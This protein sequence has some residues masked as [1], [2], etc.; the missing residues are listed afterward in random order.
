MDNE[1]LSSQKSND[2]KI[3][4]VCPE[5]TLESANRRSLIRK[6]A[7]ATAAV[8]L[9][10]TLLGKSV[11]PESSAKSDSNCG[12][13][14]KCNFV[15]WGDVVI[16]LK[17]Q[18]NGS[19]CA[20]FFNY[21]TCS[22]SGGFN[23]TPSHLLSFGIACESVC[24]TNFGCEIG[25]I[26]SGE[27]IG[28]ARTPGAV[29][30]FGL[31]FY[32]EYT[33]RMSISQHGNVGIGNSTPLHLL[34]I[35]DNQPLFN[36]NE[37]GNVGIGVYCPS[38]T[39][40]VVG[41]GGNIRAGGT[42][43]AGYGVV[44]DRGNHNSGTCIAPGLV[45]GCI[46]GVGSGEGMNSNRNCGPNKYGLD[47]YTDF[48]KRMSISH[49]GNVGIGIA[50]P[51]SSLC[52]VSNGG[53][54]H[55]EGSVVA[56][57]CLKADNNNLN[58]GSGPSQ[59]L[60]FGSAG[61]VGISSA[62]ASG[63]PNQCGLDFYT[64][65]AKRVSITKSG[66]V[67]IGTINPS[68]QLGVLSQSG[69]AIIGCSTDGTGVYGHTSGSPGYG[70]AGFAANT[71]Y[72][73]C[74]FSSKGIGVRGFGCVVGVQGL[75]NSSVA[76]PIV[77]KGTSGQTAPLQEWQNCAGTPLSVLNKC[78]WL[79][80]GNS[81]PSTPL[82]VNSPQWL[83]SRFRNSNASS[84]HSAL[85]QMETSDSTPYQWNIGAAG[86]GNGLALPDG[87]FYFEQMT[88]CH[89]SG[90][91]VVITKCGFVGIGVSAPTIPLDVA[92]C[93]TVSGKLVAG[94][95]SPSCISIP[96]GTISVS[97]CAASSVALSSTSTSPTGI[98]I[99]GTGGSIG[100]QGQANSATAIPLVAKAAGGQ[101][102]PLLQFEKSCGASLSVVNPCG[103]LGIG[104][105]S[106]P[107]TLAVAGSVSAKIVTPSGVYQMQAN[108]FA[109]LASAN[110]TLPPTS[111]AAG[112]I[113]FIKNIS[114]S[115]ITVAPSGT[116]KIEKKNSETLS[117]EYSSLTLISDGNSPGHWY[118]LSNAT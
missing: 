81:A 9:G 75:A 8:A 84:C 105:S 4:S 74:G 57:Y 108:D 40:C 87:S 61:T 116:D 82:C 79:G 12:V 36:V 63:S 94:S 45:F 11:I 35:G 16:D 104:R 58:T 7:V 46:P 53:N 44:V 42:I 51:S 18:N 31:D 19:L 32:T 60:V 106:A 52:V 59:G 34:C 70:V 43:E 89:T 41:N 110:V 30:R 5:S 109:V 39:L 69:K 1:E 33:K 25:G 65:N 2:L 115:S 76:V 23:G 54:V 15:S 93:A 29:N 55:A 62:L 6:A 107:T 47:F 80:I 102:A 78:G 92:G 117:K 14:L 50:C 98:G 20:V 66:N 99:Q 28:S 95:F 91:K 26:Q 68:S 86:S 103:W 83:V 111:T 21:V 38:T 27:G 37:C 67:G 112:M 64:D 71:G 22:D 17:N 3:P 48:D 85:I 101:T 77:A 73:V 24:G 114:S 97:D 72:G 96:K 49:C 88:K 100:V 56:G 118:I 90:A 10:G 13:F 113:V